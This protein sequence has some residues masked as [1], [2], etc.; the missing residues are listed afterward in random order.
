MW[1]KICGMTTPAA[2]SAALHAQVDAVGFVFADSPRQLTPQAAAGLAAPV[3]G[4]IRCVA[5]T[6]HPTREALD[7]ILA[8][9]KPDVLQ[10][11]MADLDELGPLPGVELLP[12][13]RAGEAVPQRLPGRILFEG[14]ASGAG[15]VCD[16]RAARQ[17][18]RRTRLVLAG[19]LNVGTVGAALSAV[20]PFGVDVSSGVEEE[21]GVKSPLKIMAF[22][23]T[24][25]AAAA[26]DGRTPASEDPL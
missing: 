15:V 4:R 1:I 23:A 6:R 21:H 14:P 13:L 22:V 7:E 8:V 9:F 12:V 3:R 16:W 26:D 11:D 25:H 2:V 5:V 18:A 10:T 19:G 17:L 20:R 24:V